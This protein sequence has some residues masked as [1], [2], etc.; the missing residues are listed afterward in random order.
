MLWSGDNHMHIYC[1]CSSLLL[2]IRK[3]EKIR[4]EEPLT[5][6][7]SPLKTHFY[8]LVF[9][10]FCYTWCLL[11]Y[12]FHLLLA[13]LYF[14]PVSYLFIYIFSLFVVCMC[15]TLIPMYPFN[16]LLTS[17]LLSLINCVY[18]WN[19]DF[20]YLMLV[21]ISNWKWCHTSGTIHWHFCC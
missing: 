7:G 9:K 13:F 19:N 5:S 12:H 6:F 2:G 11:S 4:P 17:S 8:R 15:V 3:P 20:K 16:F 21:Y 14:P 10:W 18:M 1:I